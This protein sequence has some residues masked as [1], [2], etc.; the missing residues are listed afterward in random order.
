MH[1]QCSIL[2]N[3][4]RDASEAQRGISEGDQALNLT[5]GMRNK[6]LGTEYRQ[7]TSFMVRSTP[8]LWQSPS[9]P[10][11]LKPCAQMMHAHMG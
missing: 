5:R 1:N 2:T 8:E 3:H 6:Q 10:D 9:M 7:V 4:H 11:V